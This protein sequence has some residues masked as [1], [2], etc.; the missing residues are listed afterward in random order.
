ML[1]EER[2]KAYAELG[3][4][5]TCEKDERKGKYDWKIQVGYTSSYS[6]DSKEGRVAISTVYCCV[7]VLR[8]ICHS[9]GAELDA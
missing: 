3:L 7:V 9:V 4:D 2:G 1:P 6:E 5:A 8:I